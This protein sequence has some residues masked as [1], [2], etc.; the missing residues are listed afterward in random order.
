MQDKPK[1]FLGMNIDTREDGGIKIS[2]SAYV[3]AQAE[4][5]LP[6]PLAEYPIYE[7]PSAPQLVI[8]GLRDRRT[9]ETHH[10]DAQLHYRILRVG[11]RAFAAQVYPSMHM[12]RFANTVNPN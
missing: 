7:T 3:K 4:Y 5:Y 11:F 2:A 6:K 10:R 1:Q 9:Q 8:E 12:C